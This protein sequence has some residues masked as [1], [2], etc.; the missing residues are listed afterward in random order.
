MDK[1]NVVHIHWNIAQLLK[2]EEIL[3]L[4]T[5]WMNPEDIRLKELSQSQQSIIWFRLYKVPRVAKFIE[6]RSKTVDSRSWEDGELFNDYGVSLLQ[7]KRFLY[8]A[9][10]KYLRLLNCTLKEGSDGR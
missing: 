7:G 2:S 8:K 9:M 6:T 10:W 5:T 1:Q 3:T 4:A